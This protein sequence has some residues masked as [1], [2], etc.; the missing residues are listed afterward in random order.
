MFLKTTFAPFC[1]DAI[2]AFRSPTTPTHDLPVWAT[3]SCAV[4]VRT[5]WI[6]QRLIDGLV[7]A[8]ALSSFSSSFHA[9]ITP[10]LT[11]LLETSTDSI[12]FDSIVTLQLRHTG[13][14]NSIH[15]VLPTIRWI[16]SNKKQH[17]LTLDCRFGSVCVV[18]MY[19]EY[20]QAWSCSGA[21]KDKNDAMHSFIHSRG[22]FQL[23]RDIYRLSCIETGELMMRYII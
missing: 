15:T 21:S 17:R 11:R 16:S 12:R 4:V 3:S 7:G 23:P 2:S 22:C 19:K 6:I 20:S 18:R 1:V 9:I 5:E 10:Q 14:T 8:A 13:F